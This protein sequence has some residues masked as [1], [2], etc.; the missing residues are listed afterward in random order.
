MAGQAD[1][2]AA[3][4]RGA[5]DRGH[6]GL[7]ERLQAPQDGLVL[8]H[9]GGDLLGV[10]GLGRLEVVEVAAGEEGLLGRGDDHAGDL[11]LLGFQPLD[12]DLDRLPVGG[13]HRVRRL[14]GVVEGQDHDPVVVLVPA[15][16]AALRH[17]FSLAFELDPAH[18]R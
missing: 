17:A 11:V 16:R 13:V 15:D 6:H 14:V 10:I 1:L 9:P 5:V 4:Q 7:A 2:Q 3:A 12:D 18:P 8:T